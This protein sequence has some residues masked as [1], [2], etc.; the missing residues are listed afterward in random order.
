MSLFPAYADQAKNLEESE[1]P[2]TNEEWLEN[3]S[4]K[5]HLIVNPPNEN[6]ISIESSD[7][8]I[9]EEISVPK[10][11]K[12]DK[13]KKHHRAKDSKTTERQVQ[14][15]ELNQNFSLDLTQT[16]ELLTV[17][18]ITRPAVAK[19][20]VQYYLSERTRNRKHRFKRYFTQSRNKSTESDKEE[21]K[22][23]TLTKQN[24]DKVGFAKKDA[25]FTGFR[26]EEEL[27][28]RTAHF[29]RNLTDNPTDVQMWLKY[30][31]FQDTVYQF[32]KSYRK[33]S[34]AKAQRVLAERKISI[35][36]KALTNNQGNEQL[37]RERLRV[38]VSAF[39]ADEL[40]TQLKTVIEKEKDN[41]VLWQGYIEATQCSMAHCNSPAVLALYIECLS[42]MHKLRRTTVSEK[43]I[44][45]QGILRTLFQ[46]GL[47][48]KQ[49]G[50]FEQLWTVL[51]MYLELNLTSSNKAIFNVERYCN[52]KEL[53][54]LE[55]VVLNS[56]LPHHELW[57]RVEKLRE[58]CHWLPRMGDQDC[59]DP[60]RIV[61]N[62]DVVELIH[63][64]TSPENI[65]KLVATILT[66]LKVPFLPCR[67]STMQDLGLDYVPWC[68]DSI[69]TLLPV[70][71]PMYSIDISNK[72][73][74][75]DTNRLAVGPQYIK[76]LPGQEEYLSLIM[77]V[78]ESCA[79]CLKNQDQLAVRIWW[80]K[81]QRLLI[82]LDVQGIFK[83][84]PNFKKKIKTNVKDLLKREEYRNNEIF[85]VEYALIEKLF[86]NNDQCM[87]ILKTALSMNQN[88]SIQPENWT[89]TQT[90]QCFLYRILVEVTIELK[91]ENVKDSVLELLVKLVLQRQI[92]GV[93][94]GLIMEAET[95]FNIVTTALL[96]M[97][98]NN[99]KAVEHF[100]PDFLTEWIICNGWFIFWSK[101]P[102][103]AGSFLEN[104]ISTL[105]AKS[106]GLSFQIEVLHEFYCS[107]LFKYCVE[108]PGSGIFK[109]LDK[110][111]FKSIEKYPNNLYLLAVLAKEQ[112]LTKNMGISAW[113]VQDLLLKS[114]RA[115]ATIFTLFLSDLVRLE[116]ENAITDSITGTK[117]DLMV[118]FKNKT[119]S[120]FKRI[121]GE[122]MCTRRCGLAWRLYLQFVQAYFGQELCRN[123]YYCA[124][125][126]CPWLKSLYM[127]AAIYI[128]A[129]LAQI[130]DLII[131]KQLRLHVTPEELDI[132]RN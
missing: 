90:N 128:P 35:L 40:Q 36:D 75:R 29:N 95:K 39:P 117:C 41:I 14:E 32:E 5:P 113:K 2:V 33:G 49:A 62:E 94:N 107:I 17:N 55:E 64:I 65:F 31:E 53:L 92:T 21:S 80:F 28:R 115:V 83:I 9:V 15:P 60:Q 26:Q 126:Q 71:L 7:D 129:E 1:R 45:E 112:S 42:T 20:R 59:E 105:E 108:N 69:E 34:I 74:L 130:Q 10:K 116:H 4:F 76:A 81:F 25:N 24:L 6:S 13:K 78:M 51:K 99:L 85:Y 114:G 12:K 91:Q 19:Y 61:F 87:R 127:D 111:L 73:L 18:T 110:V 100:L 43:Y 119:L 103:K 16:R 67:H 121:T 86:G 89:E 8:D 72:N 79:E 104:A 123:V 93:T 125:E 102:L 30:V 101:G 11:R 66:L 97:E 70:F 22:E 47:F 98:L 44:F 46:C 52:E 131:E 84:P 124:V 58:A 68:L 122:G 38:A 120:L 3:S 77:A 27:S 48:L 50:L 132:L 23:Q 106:V 54:E 56:Q 88:T 82:I 109:M 96:D 118:S 63:P 37:L 57:L